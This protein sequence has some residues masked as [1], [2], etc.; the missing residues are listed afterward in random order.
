MCRPKGM[1]IQVCNRTKPFTMWINHCWIFCWPL[2]CKY[3]DTNR[4]LSVDIGKII[5]FTCQRLTV[6]ILMLIK[7]W[8][9]QIIHLINYDFHVNGDDMWNASLVWLFMRD[10][11]KCILFFFHVCPFQLISRPL[12]SQMC[13]C[14]VLIVR[15]SGK[16][17]ISK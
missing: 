6:R 13:L 16:L 10:I 17:I 9:I 7:S 1:L 5:I 11:S 12:T 4:N 15:W 3:K 8:P 14:S 2:G